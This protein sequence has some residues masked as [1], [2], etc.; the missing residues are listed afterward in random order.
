M[1]MHS[2]RLAVGCAVLAATLT[3]CGSGLS[4]RYGT[5]KDGADFNFKSGNRVEIT[6]L[7]STR[8]GTYKLED[9]K[10]YITAANDTQAFKFNA[11]GCIDGGFMFGTLC[12][13]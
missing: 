9:G 1:I 2:I 8:V 10:V 13:Q 7:G 5:E 3:A 12:K 4:G 6:V 11:Q